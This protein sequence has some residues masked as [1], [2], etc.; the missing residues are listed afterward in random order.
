[1]KKVVAGTSLVA[2]LL[3]FLSLAGFLW[4]REQLKPVS[5]N[6]EVSEFV[7]TK[8]A[9]VEKVGED[10]YNKGFIKSSLAFKMFVQLSDK[11]QK[12]QAGQFRLSPSY[13][14]PQIVDSLSKGPQEL[15]VTIPE[16]L[17][18]EEIAEKVI[19]SLGM[20][21][22]QEETFRT[23]FLGETEDVE[24]ML[25][26][27]TYLFPRE[28][29][30]SRVVLTMKN[31]F[32]KKVDSTMRSTISNRGYTLNQVVTLAS[33]VERESKN[34]TKDERPIIAGIYYNRLKI[35]MPLQADATVQ[36][37][38]A[39]T[40]CKITSVNCDWW[41]TIQRADYEFKHP[42]STYTNTGFPPGPISNP[43]IT[44]IQAAVN[45][46]DTDY[47][48][49]IH[50]DNGTPHYAKNLQEHNQNIQQYL[51]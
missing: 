24:G 14:L 31:T 40:K 22:A 38:L 29:D 11:T 50:E 2:F 21:G 48:Y 6:T 41:P 46:L 51:R 23:Q 5:H 37:A 36:Y 3:V 39:T 7:I 12:V 1:M 35:G 47:L 42:Y 13:T 10:L 28:V 15:W 18:R 20:T 32:D 30:A 49:Y 19:D 45:P 33:I 4:W 17:R 43:G 25:F 34:K 44:S 16:G 8:G 9:T 26:P 27:D